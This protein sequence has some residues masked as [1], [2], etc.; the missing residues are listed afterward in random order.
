M[1]AIFRG[2]I[3][4]VPVCVMLRSLGG[5]VL[6]LFIV[7]QCRAHAVSDIALDLQAVNDCPAGQKLDVG[8]GMCMDANPKQEPENKEEPTWNVLEKQD[9]MPCGLQ[10]K[11]DLC[12]KRG[13]GFTRVCLAK[14]NAKDKTYECTSR[15]SPCKL[16]TKAPDNCVLWKRRKVV[17]YRPSLDVNA[18]FLT[19]DMGPV[20]FCGAINCP[21]LNGAIEQAETANPSAALCKD[22]FPSNHD[23]EAAGGAHKP[24]KSAMSIQLCMAKVLKPKACSA[25]ERKARGLKPKETCI[26]F[27]AT[28][29]C[30][31]SFAEDMK[32]VAGGNLMGNPGIANER[33]VF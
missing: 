4:A 28:K 21:T 31:T 23:H 10:A 19:S 1:G 15:M 11:V 6:L 25:E 17:L 16:D 33:A 20:D 30:A 22:M 7:G 8:T 14:W 18:S 2:Q 29:R 9:V 5:V 32:K 26:G 13:E 3:G 27:D 24:T 12:A